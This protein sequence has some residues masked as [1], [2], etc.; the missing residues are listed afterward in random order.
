VRALL[1]LFTIYASVAAAHSVVLP[2]AA[3][4]WQLLLRL[5]VRLL[6]N[7]VLSN[8]LCFVA[9]CSCCR[10]FNPGLKDPNG[11]VQAAKSAWSAHNQGQRM[12]ILSGPGG[13]Q[14]N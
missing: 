11:F 6:L 5:T 7:S 4:V 3:V 10:M 13:Q 12:T 1:I 9:C 14:M 2:S 8:S